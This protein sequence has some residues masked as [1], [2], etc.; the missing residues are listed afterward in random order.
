MDAKLIAAAAQVCVAAGGQSQS[1]DGRSEID[2]G[3]GGL[4]VVEGTLNVFGVGP[5]GRR[6]RVGTAHGG[7]LLRQGV[8]AVNQEDARLYAVPAGT[9]T[10]IS[11]SARQLAEV[12]RNEAISKCLVL[13][14][15]AFDPTQAQAMVREHAS[16]MTSAA[17]AR[18]AAARLA[19]SRL[20]SIVRGLFRAQDELLA[21]DPALPPMLRACRHV[22]VASGVQLSSIPRRLPE[23]S[24]GGA[25]EV[26]AHLARIGSRRVELA[27]GWWKQDSGPILATQ[28]RDQSPV[29]LV[30]SGGYR[31]GYMA[32]VYL[33]E[34]VM[35]P[36]SVDTKRAAAMSRSARVF[37]AALPAP[38]APLMEL[39]QFVLRGSAPDLIRAAVLAAGASIL[40][41]LVPLGT[42]LLVARLLPSGVPT[43]LLFLLLALSSAVIASSACSFVCSLYLVRVEARSGTRAST[44]VLDRVFRLPMSF[45]RQNSAG[46]L[47]ARIGSVDDLQRTVTSVVMGTVVG[48]AFALAYILL[49]ACIDWRAALVALAIVSVVFLV[50]AFTAVAQARLYSVAMEHGGRLGGL[51]LQMIRGIE[52]VRTS[53]SEDSVLLTWLQRFRRQR[54]LQ[55]RADLQGVANQVV[56]AAAPVVG[57]ILLWWMFGKSNGAGTA[58]S[59]VSIATY[60]AFYAAFSAALAAALGCARL[61]GSLAQ[62]APAIARLRPILDAV[63]EVDRGSEQPG[64]LTGAVALENIR[65]S[66]P[67]SAGETLKGVS[68]EAKPGEFIAI[69]GQ[70]GS[71][72]STLLQ[73]LLG[74]RRSTGGKVLLD[75]RDLS[76][77]DLVAV[78]RQIGTVMQRPR[79]VPASIFSCI[80]GSGPWTLDDAWDAAEAAGLADAI[81]EMPMEMHTVVSD[82]TL[83]GGQLQKLMLAQALVSRPKLL[84]LDEATS[85]LD[86][87]SQSHVAASLADLAATRIVVAHRLSTVVH[88]HRIYVLESGRVVQHGTYEQLMQESGAFLA[89]V[90]RQNLTSA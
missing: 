36:L 14:D 22:A 52:K 54:R 86:E 39:L 17:G 58:G 63:P 16:E 40:N 76:R 18:A 3:P 68:I 5:M 28:S 20:V 64:V 11:L 46:D 48:G 53:G 87:I 34:S 23:N 4:L 85:A 55:Y 51:L 49:L 19:P 66:H 79:I 71:G 38:R 65:F 8:A 24:V 33:P 62:A 41:L 50:G 82:S 12:T 7:A 67:G 42:A 57:A 43:D 74:L 59:P 88:A 78:R 35:G 80:V 37:Y 70:S 15:E 9:A 56:M 83:S 21:V 60:M 77:L 13:G 45:F 44:A 26:F 10:I 84:V 2:M 69:V 89:L 27:D 75:G 73:I 90:E 81:R 61:L 32:F 29:A 72:K 1:A 25:D 30:W 47:A 6:V 31:G